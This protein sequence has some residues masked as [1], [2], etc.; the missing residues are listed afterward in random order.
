MMQPLSPAH[1]PLW[2]TRGLGRERKVS[3]RSG[4]RKGGGGGGMAKGKARKRLFSRA[5]AI[6][7]IRLI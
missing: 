2:V 3:A 7:I 1:K 6:F 4:W 5:H